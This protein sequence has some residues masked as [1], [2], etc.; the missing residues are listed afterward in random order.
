[1]AAGDGSEARVTYSHT[2][3]GPEG[4]TYVAAFTAVAYG[5]SVRDWEARVNHY[6]QTGTMLRSPG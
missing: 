4:D 2:S 6:L 3:L 5:K 1:M